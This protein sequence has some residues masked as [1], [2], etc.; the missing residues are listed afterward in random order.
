MCYVTAHWTRTVDG[1]GPF[2]VVFVHYQKRT[3]VER[4]CLLD[5]CI[6]TTRVSVYMQTRHR[7]RPD[8]RLLYHWPVLHDTV[9]YSV[10]LLKSKS[11]WKEKREHTL[12]SHNCG[13]VWRF[14]HGSALSSRR[15]LRNK[16]RRKDTTLVSYRQQRHRSARSVLILQAFLFFRVNF[17][18]FRFE[19]LGVWRALVCVGSFHTR[20]A[21]R[22]NKFSFFFFSLS[23]SVLFYYTL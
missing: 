8:S 10:A 14:E 21:Y 2:V 23:L 3:H 12:E 22:W 9:V 18:V 1:D 7:T 15:M 11:K 4:D 19:F 20:F 17:V 16:R 6:A 13:D 5:H